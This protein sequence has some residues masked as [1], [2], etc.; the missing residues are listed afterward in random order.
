MRVCV[1]SLSNQA[2]NAHTPYCH[3][4]PAPLYHIFPHYLINDTILG[5]QKTLKT[6]FVFRFPLP[7]LPEAFLILRRIERDTIKNV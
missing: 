5:K 7:F 4:R 1:C 3:L 2:F 6:K